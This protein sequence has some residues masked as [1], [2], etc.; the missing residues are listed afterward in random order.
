[1]MK[2][3]FTKAAWLV[4]GLSLLSSCEKDKTE[5]TPVA[6]PTPSGIECTPTAN[7]LAF[8]WTAVEGAMAYRYEFQDE[9]AAVISGDVTEAAWTKD[10]LLSESEYKFRLKAIPAVDS[11]KSLESEWSEWMSYTTTE[12]AIARKFASGSGTEDDPYIIMTAGQL[13]YLAQVVN[14]ETEGFCEFG[15]F[16]EL[17]AD[18]DL[19]GYESWEPIGIGTGSKCLNTAN[20]DNKCSFRGHFSGA[21]HTISNLNIVTS[22]NAD[23]IYIGLFGQNC[24]WI[25]FLNVEGTVSV[26]SNYTEGG[27]LMVGG[28][29]GYS[30]I[31]YDAEGEV[32]NKTGGIV[33]CSFKGSVTAD[34]NT[35]AAGY[36]VCGGIC[37]YAN[38]GNIDNC[39]LTL[40]KSM[41][42][43][44]ISGLS[45]CAGGVVG[46]F[47]AGRMATAT[48][49]IAGNVIAEFADKTA[50]H[51]NYSAMAGGVIGSCG[52]LQD[53][54]TSGI[55]NCNIKV[56]GNILAIANGNYSSAG[57][58]ALVAASNADLISSCTAEISG[59][60]SAQSDDSIYVG[61]LIGSLVSAYGGANQVNACSVTITNSGEV[62][63]QQKN[64][65]LASMSSSMNVGG[66]VGGLGNAVIG[67]LASCSVTIE[68]KLTASNAS[69]GTHPT[70]C[71]G[72]IG[73][74]AGVGGCYTILK[75]GATIEVSG[76][77][78]NVG[79]VAGI[80]R[81][82]TTKRL[83]GCYSLLDGTIKTHPAVAG[84]A[85]YAVN[86]GGIAG[87]VAGSRV[88][89]KFQSAPVYSCYSLFRTSVATD[90]NGTLN[91]GA[92]A[93]FGS[94]YIFISNYWSST[95]TGMFGF[96][97]DTAESA[98][99][100]TEKFISLDRAG[101][102]AAMGVM[103]QTLIDNGAT[104]QF[105]YDATLG[106]LTF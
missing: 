79:G 38:S 73:A 21:Y 60:I 30:Q 72:V 9:A 54:G 40:D 19:K 92:I 57:A 56:S 41:S 34:S 87:S 10:G 58:G 91:K 35:D 1:M 33:A 66:L 42:I 52:R 43:H 104:A 20:P 48:V 29:S 85:A 4:A 59:R 70:N 23:E 99:S 101:F 17:G 75:E 53:A 90:A 3:I 96:G 45:P 14:N 49:T 86:A 32:V 7:S 37:G 94:R 28:V 50:S 15:V 103:N 39:T 16:Y 82:G 51:E 11:K 61:G 69:E 13:A 68:G 27:Y 6:L 78:I 77:T 81:G 5:I 18:I 62:I 12:G 22:G 47:N 44:S 88:G 83:I 25:E 26:K 95:D 8:I 2:K 74:S 31:G 102:E 67:E 36:A 55:G 71:G 46:N 84:A 106:Y 97:T 24:G 76:G 98:T 80:F 100:G 105:K 63:G 93:G 65:T 89:N 64:T